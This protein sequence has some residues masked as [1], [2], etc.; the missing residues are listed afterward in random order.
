M[1]NPPVGTVKCT[2]AMSHDEWPFQYDWMEPRSF[3]SVSR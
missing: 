1:T 2:L 3:P